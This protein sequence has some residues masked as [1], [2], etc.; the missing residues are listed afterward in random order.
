[1]CLRGHVGRHRQLNAAVLKRSKK[2]NCINR[3]YRFT[4]LP[5]LYM[6]AHWHI[7]VYTQTFMKTIYTQ[8]TYT[9]LCV[10][11]LSHV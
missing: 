9:W 10:F 5:Y 11:M 4:K 8:Y 2:D 6:Y 1:M 7:C 3:T